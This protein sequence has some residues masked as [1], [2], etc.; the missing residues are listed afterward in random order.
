V[1]TIVAI[2]LAT[3]AQAEPN[4]YLCL[5]EQAVGLHY[6][7]KTSLWGPIA[8]KPEW[9]FILRRLTEDD[10]AKGEYRSLYQRS[11]GQRAVNWAV[12]EHGKSLPLAL[13][14]D[15]SPGFVFFTCEP[16][17]HTF[18]FDANSLRFEIITHGGFAAQGALEYILRERR[19][20]PEQYKFAGPPPSEHGVS[21]PDDLL[22]AIGKCSPI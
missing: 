16:V 2:A 20:H 12:F 14:S 3:A 17:A 4:Q 5:A 22:V 11:A 21:H 18:S 9:K 7:D 19:E 15:G 6:D 8:F 10:R 13:C 1:A